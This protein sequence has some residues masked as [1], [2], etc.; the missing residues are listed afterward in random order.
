MKKI[1]IHVV[2]LSLLFAV[3]IYA[4][5]VNE[6]VQEMDEEVQ[7]QAETTLSAT[8]TV[9]EDEEEVQE[10][11]PFGEDFQKG[12]YADVT[13]YAYIEEVDEAWCEEDCLKYEYVFFKITD[14][15]DS[16][17][18]QKIIEEEQGNMFF[19]EGSVGLGCS[20]DGIITYYNETGMGE[21][22]EY[23]LSQEL[24]GK[25]LASDSENQISLR[26]I[27]KEQ[28]GGQGAPTCYSHFTKIEELQD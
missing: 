13:G 17:S 21:V 14:F 22:E 12:G 7:D 23:S 10:N 8:I 15:G 28:L 5:C 19:G 18:L 4:G 27:K 16:E 6:G 2:L 11:I 24:S 9:T 25:I 3:L 20:D 1:I 26:L